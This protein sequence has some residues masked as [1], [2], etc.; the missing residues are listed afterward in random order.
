[1]TSGIRVYGNKNANNLG[2]CRKRDWLKERYAEGL[3]YPSPKTLPVS[4]P[5]PIPIPLYKTCWFLNN[6][7]GVL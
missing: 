4:V 3:R 7:Y 1:M 2:Y 5:I 6:C